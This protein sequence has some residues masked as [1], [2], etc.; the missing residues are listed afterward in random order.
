MN[1]IRLGTREGGKP[2]ILP[3]RARATHLQVIGA[4]GTGKTKFL[5]HLIRQ[6][7]VAGN[8]FCLI[9][10]TGNL[11]QDLVRWCETKEFLGR[12]PLVLFDPASH[13]WTFGFNPL[14]F[15]NGPDEDLSFYVDSMVKACATVWGG[16]DTN[17]TP[18][19]KRCLRATFHVLAEKRLTLLEALYLVNPQDATGIRRSLTREIGDFVMRDQWDTF[20]A[21]KPREFEEHFASTT[22]RLLEFLASERIRRI[23]GQ[24]EGVLRFR[25]LMDRGG[26]LLVNLS[27]GRTLSEANASLLGALLVNDAF[28]KAR[29]RPKGSRPFYLYIDECPRFVN[30]DIG[31]ILDE[32]RQFGLHLVLAHQHLSQLQRAGEAVYGAVLTDARTKVVFGGLSPEDAETMAEVIYM[33]EFDFEEA[34]TSL[35]K[36]VTV[37]HDLRW[38]ASE[39]TT[40]GRSETETTGRA[41]ARGTSATTARTRGRSES[42]GWADAPP[43][44]NASPFLPSLNRNW[45]SGTSVTTSTAHGRSESITESESRSV[46]MSRSAT[47]GRSEGLVPVLEV[48][49]TAVFSLE[50]QRHR[51]AAILRNL[52]RQEAVLKMPERPSVAFRAARVEEGYANPERVER[53]KRESFLRSRFA[54]P[55]AAVDILLSVR[56][57]SL[58]R[59]AQATEPKA[60]EDFL[61]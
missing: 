26:M 30:E 7:I 52:R 32:G 34:K 15:E 42:D 57:R 48:L 53:F 61:E 17:R 2:V 43:G 51:K 31:R 10:P 40:T 4:S 6:D 21:A 41:V 12:K 22:N 38:F 18:L 37:G 60:P 14:D 27:S 29:G 59:A 9:D 47:E 35:N 16:E 33:G 23:L 28:L 24:R 56:H 39:A 46:G 3:E 25:E 5:E 45:S 50:E 13:E 55:T 36:P 49:P 1:G 44:P 8:G 58:E 54:K 20:N 19:L 11:Y